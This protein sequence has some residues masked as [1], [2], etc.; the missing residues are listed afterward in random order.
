MIKGVYRNNTALSRLFIFIG[1]VLFGFGLSTILSFLTIQLLFGL[2]VLSHPELLTNFSNPESISAL[3]F[4][5][6]MNSTGIFI[7]PVLAFAYLTSEK[8][9]NYLSLNIKPTIRHII[10]TLLIMFASVPLINF[11]V[12]LNSKMIL[13]D[14]LQGVENWMQSKE[15]GAETITKV[16][17]KMDDTFTFLINLLVIGFIPAIGEELLFRGLIQKRLSSKFKNHHLAIWITAFLFSAMHLQFYGFLPRFFLGAMFGYLFVW[18]GSIWIP[19]IAH[20]INNGGAVILQY[21]LGEEYMESKVDKLGIE[22]G[23]LY[24]L[25]ISLV[26]LGIMLKVFYDSGDKS[27]GTLRK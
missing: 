23:E 6:F 20:L 19:I 5:Q 12:E 8:V 24:Y 18:S 9:L 26:A 22:E 17:L 16:F 27:G 11:L 13:P 2:D 21:S 3:K 14:Y 15:D 4:M 25:A 7:F 1:L 10:I